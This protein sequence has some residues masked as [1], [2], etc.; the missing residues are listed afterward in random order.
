MR[1]RSTL[2]RASNMTKSGANTANPQTAATSNSPLQS[3]SAGDAT[4]KRLET[5]QTKNS[6]RTLF[7]K[8]L[9]F[10]PQKLGQIFTVDAGTPFAQTAVFCLK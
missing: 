1:V 3:K 5:Q 9:R 4:P 7:G 6:A 2:A 10:A 8:L